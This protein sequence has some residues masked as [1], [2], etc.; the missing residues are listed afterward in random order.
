VVLTGEK[1]IVIFDTLGKAIS[2]FTP[3]EDEDA[4]WTPLFGSDSR[5]LLLFD[6]KKTLYR[7]ELPQ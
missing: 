7:F 6:G 2:R 5:G 3:L 1:A 4:A